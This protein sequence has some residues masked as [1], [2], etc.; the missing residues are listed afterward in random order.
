MASER[1]LNRIIDECLDRLLVRGETVE[2]CLARYPEQARELEPLLRV[3]LQAQQVL[4]PSPRPEAKAQARLKLGQ[5]LQQHGQSARSGLRW[6]RLTPRWTAAGAAALAFAV[7]IGGGAGAVAASSGSLPTDPLYGVKRKAESVRVFFAADD[8]SKAGVYAELADR[9]LSEM[10]IM[11]SQGRPVEVELLGRDLREHLERIKVLA[12]VSGLTPIGVGGIEVTPPPG[13]QDG[14]LPTPVLPVAVIPG[15]PETLAGIMERNA[16]RRLQQLEA[17]LEVA[18]PEARPRIKEAIAKT[19][20]R[21]QRAV[22]DIK[23]REQEKERE[24]PGKRQ[25]QQLPPTGSAV[26]PEPKGQGTPRRVRPAEGTGR[27]PEGTKPV[28]PTEGTA[29][30]PL[31]PQQGNRPPEKP[32]DGQKR[33]TP[34]TPAPGE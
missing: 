29:R 1:E 33:P 4:A 6:P 26:T 24:K 34:A 25:G 16:E 30:P 28:R 5:A 12:G 10:A 3:V 17:A 2:S 19:Q 31:R 9:R 27:P 20:E 32:S 8:D 13:G 7:V 15:R 21:Y 23:R 14:S 18:P 11:A 22:D